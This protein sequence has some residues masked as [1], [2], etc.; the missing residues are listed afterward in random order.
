MTSFVHRRIRIAGLSV[1][2][3]VV[4]VG[5]LVL[6]FQ[7]AWERP[8]TGAAAVLNFVSE[9]CILLIILE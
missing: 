6:Y 8:V 9:G 7:Y 2:S 3:L 1:E 5:V 4:L